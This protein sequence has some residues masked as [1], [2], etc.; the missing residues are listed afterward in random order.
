MRSLEWAILVPGRLAR[1]RD[2]RRTP[3]SENVVKLNE[4]NNNVE[5]AEKPNLVQQG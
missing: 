4:R 5:E 3:L 1:D 2:Q